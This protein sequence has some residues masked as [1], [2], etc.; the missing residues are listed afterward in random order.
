MKKE[1]LIVL[2]GAFFLMLFTGNLIQ[3]QNAD[4]SSQKSFIKLSDNT[5]PAS[6]KDTSNVSAF[7][8]IYPKFS[9]DRVH[10]SEY[11]EVN[12]IGKLY[13]IHLVRTLLFNEKEIEWSKDG[14]FGEAVKLDPGDNNLT[15][16]VVYSNGI[17]NVSHFQ[18]RYVSRSVSGQ[19][20]TTVGLSQ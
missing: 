1:K 13:D 16:K 19:K 9:N 8:I 10:I 6:K 4:I 15:V 17:E 14:L 2:F 20:E 5:I 12:F 18:I 3:A 7:T 11:E